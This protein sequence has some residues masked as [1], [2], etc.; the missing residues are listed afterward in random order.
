M[1][2]KLQGKRQIIGGTRGP[3]RPMPDGHRELKELVRRIYIVAKRHPDA[4][5]HAGLRLL[6]EELEIKKHLWKNE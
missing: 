4:Q 6:I 1:E 3:P 2:K 5:T